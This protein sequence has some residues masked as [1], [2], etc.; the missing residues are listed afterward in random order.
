VAL[1][2]LEAR[3]RLR[4][5]AL[6]TLGSIAYWQHDYGRMIP[7]YEEALEIAREVGDRRL[8]AEALHN[9]SFMRIARGEAG[10]D[11]GLTREAL[12]EARAAGDAYLEG[13]IRDSMGFEYMIRGDHARALV[14]IEEAVAFHRRVGQKASLAENLNALAALEFARGDRASGDRHT[15]E[16]FLT[17]LDQGNLVGTAFALIP[18]AVAAAGHGR[19][20]RAATLATAS[21][22]WQEELGGSPPAFVR[23]YYVDPDAIA[24]EHLS[25]EE[26]ERAVENGRTMSFDQAVAFALEEEPADPD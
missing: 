6:G 26:Y 24:R 11:E 18:L 9:A 10:P 22:R 7:L 1:P 8:L 2:G 16:A 23:S 17:H 3:D 4:A 12:G 20:A 19:F 15:R 5:V 21:A 13:R 14:A 25:E